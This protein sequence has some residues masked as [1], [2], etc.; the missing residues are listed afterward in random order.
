MEVKCFVAEIVVLGVLHAGRTA[1]FLYC[2]LAASFYGKCRQIC[3]LDSFTGIDVFVFGSDVK[4]VFLGT[5][6]KYQ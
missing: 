1:V 2:N 5:S 3:A 4:E 6:A